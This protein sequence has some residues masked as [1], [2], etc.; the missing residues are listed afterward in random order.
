MKSKAETTESDGRQ[1]ESAD[2]CRHIQPSSRVQ[3]FPTFA[4]LYSVVSPAESSST[5][6]RRVIHIHSPGCF[7]Q[8]RTRTRDNKPLERGLELFHLL[9]IRFVVLPFGP[10]LPL[11]LPLPPLQAFI[12]CLGPRPIHSTP[13]HSA[14]LHSI[15]LGNSSS[16][17]FFVFFEKKTKQNLSSSHLRRAFTFVSL[18]LLLLLHQAR[19]TKFLFFCQIQKSA[20]HRFGK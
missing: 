10:P 6:K 17:A 2:V 7:L 20:F 14:A 3:A 18:C 19:G 12:S 13:L 4:F 16:T 9:F 8:R 15:P 1:A 11:P 5:T